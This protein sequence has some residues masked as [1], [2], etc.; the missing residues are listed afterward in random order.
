MDCQD[1]LV[2]DFAC[3]VS[4]VAID[5]EVPGDE[6][7]RW[8]NCKDTPLLDDLVAAAPRLCLRKTIDDHFDELPGPAHRVSA[9]L[10]LRGTTPEY[11]IPRLDDELISEI[12]AAYRGRDGDAP[13]SHR[14]DLTEVCAFLS[15]HRGAGV[16]TAGDPEP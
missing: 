7:R 15:A 3:E 11:V 6:A 14:A 12:L 9:V 13:G 10:F 16:L 2:T 1:D 4:L 5:S 8:W